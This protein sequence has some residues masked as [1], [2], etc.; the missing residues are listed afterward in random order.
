V[1][2]PLSPL[3]EEP[4]FIVVEAVILPLLCLILPIQVCHPITNSCNWIM[5]MQLLGML[6]IS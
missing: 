6:S 5:R 4:L 2:A 3:G 1:E